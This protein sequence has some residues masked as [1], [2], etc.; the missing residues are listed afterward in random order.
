MR[1]P[2]Y[3]H[4]SVIGQRVKLRHFSHSIYDNLNTLIANLQ[5]AS[6]ANVIF[7]VIRHCV[8]PWRR[9]KLLLDY[10][11]S[12]WAQLHSLQVV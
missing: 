3:A 11:Y 5:I 12:D 1:T 2:R 9:C 6:A 7:P 10:A 4:E 8:W